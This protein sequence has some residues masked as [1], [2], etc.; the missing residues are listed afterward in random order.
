MV[1]GSSRGHPKNVSSHIR[2]SLAHSNWRKIT[3]TDTHCAKKASEKCQADQQS[4]RS[5][6]PARPLPPMLRNC[7]HI[8]PK[9]QCCH[10]PIAG[11]VDSSSSASLGLRLRIE[12][13]LRWVPFGSVVCASF[14]ENCRPNWNEMTLGLTESGQ[15]GRRK[16]RKESKKPTIETIFGDFRIEIFRVC[17]RCEKCQTWLI[18][19]FFLCCII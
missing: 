4:T 1:R 9:H 3:K 16:G 18:F 14:L 5:A 6:S 7:L 17:L 2:S 19:L 15:K 13:V 12:L 8:F 10:L 11:V